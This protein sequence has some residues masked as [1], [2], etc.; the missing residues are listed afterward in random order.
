MGIQFFPGN[1]NFYFIFVC[2]GGVRIT[3]LA[4]LSKSRYIIGDYETTY[5]VSGG[6]GFGYRFFETTVNLEYD[7][8][9][10]LNPS[11]YAGLN[12]KMG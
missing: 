4:L 7:G 11:I 2:K 6:T 10:K 12:F 3:E 1:K 8:I 5:Y 9:G